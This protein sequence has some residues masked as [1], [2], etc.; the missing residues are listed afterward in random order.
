MKAPGADAVAAV[1]AADPVEAHLADLTAALHGP[2]RVKARMVAEL[3]EGLLDAVR[4]LSPG[5]GPDPAAARQAVD[6]FGTVAEIAPDFQRELT[7]AQA[8]HTARTVVL[9]VPFLFLCW[10]FV[11]AHGRRAGRPLPDPAQLVVLHLGGVAALTALL[12][13][14]F[15]AA[16]GVL[17]RR[18]PTPERLPL[19]VAWTGTTAAA[20]LALSALTLTVASVLATSWLLTTVAGV[21]TIAFHTRMA[22]SARAC[23]ECALLPV[24]SA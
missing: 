5:P 18:L 2:A 14:G 13:A 11:E 21:V 19:A 3:R 1:T 17:A 8:R 12:A 10:Y 22:A 4:D 7:I 20:A 23:R 9:I 16:T 6:E 15:L 24:T